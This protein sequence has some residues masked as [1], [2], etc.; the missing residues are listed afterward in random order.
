M[1][2]SLEQSLLWTGERYL[3]ELQGDIELEHLH[4]YL[5]AKQLTLNKR[6]LDIASG[7]GYGSA[8][9]AQSAI[10]VVGV[11][12]ATDA[13]AH[14][15]AK[16]RA[17]NLEYRLGS[18]SVIPL[19]DHS[20]DVVVSFETI[21]HHDEHEAMMC[22]I[23]RVLI[24][25]GLLVISCPDKFEYSDR[26][27]FDNPYHVKELYRNEFKSLLETYFKKHRIAGQRVIY[28]SAIFEEDELTHIKS[29]D[30]N[31]NPLHAFSGVPHA[32]YLVA[33]ASDAELPMIE[34][35]VLEQAIN[36]SEIVVGFN[37]QI[38]ELNH[39]LFERDQF[40]HELVNSESWRITKPLRWIGKLSRSNFI[41]TCFKPLKNALHL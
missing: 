5:I 13:V 34:S 10:S 32:L 27:N 22:E 2:D 28:G 36:E 23:K 38:A 31:D 11:D 24:P 8:L 20:V 29:Y 14:A 18:C 30:L 4:R 39:I 19:A 6:V 26:P 37:T 1:N 9:L 40:I 15:T 3:P 16:Y 7:E 21:E 12:I 41:I 17:D 25:G 33:V 35:G